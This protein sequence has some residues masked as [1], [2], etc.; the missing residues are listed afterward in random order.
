MMNPQ[1]IYDPGVFKAI[2]NNIADGVLVLDMEKR[3]IHLNPAA[4]RTIGLPPKDLIN[5]KCSEVFGNNNCQ[6]CPID[7]SM[8]EWKTVVN[9]RAELERSDGSKIP[10][11]KNTSPLFNDKNELIGVVEVFQDISSLK[12]LEK[13]RTEFLAMLAHDLKTPTLS[14]IGFAKRLLDNRAGELNDKQRRYIEIIERSAQQLERLLSDFILV[15]KS[16][17]GG[18]RVEIESMDFIDVIKDVEEEFKTRAQE[19]DI[20]ILFIM[21]KCPIRIKGD[22]KQLRR[23]LTNI[24]DNAL[25]FTPLGGQIKVVLTP[26][27]DRLRVDVSDN[28]PGI[29][30]QDLPYIFDKFYRTKG[31]Q[32]SEGSGL[33]LA[34]AKSIIEAHRGRICAKS[35]IGEG[36]TITFWLPIDI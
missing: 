30:E 15:T 36:T 19:K 31:G 23:V 32:A 33:G 3:I 6:L 27:G 7:I 8:H 11:I 16:Q 14:I 18:L 34:I 12:T 22:M 1:D 2:F 20:E 21:P 28:G 4:A 35:R 29:K 25:Q 17:V 24:L 5:K 26:K 10:I 13:E 9:E